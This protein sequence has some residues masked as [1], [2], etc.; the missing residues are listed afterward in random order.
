MLAAIQFY[1]QAGLDATKIDDELADA[2]LPPKLQTFKT[3]GPQIMPKFALG[4]RLSPP[5]LAGECGF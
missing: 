1:D 4:I 5:E 2:M 3:P